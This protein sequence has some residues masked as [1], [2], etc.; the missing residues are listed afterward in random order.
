MADQDAGQTNATDNG[1]NAGGS[2][3]DGAKTDTPKTFTE[4][5][6][7][8]EADRRVS[9]A[10]KKWREEQAELLAAKDKDAETKIKELSSKAEEAQ[11]YGDFVDAAHSAGIRNIKA[12]YAVA[13]AH[14]HIN[15]RGKFDVDAVRK[16]NPEFFQPAANANAGAGAG[17]ATNTGGMNAYIR[18]A[19]GLG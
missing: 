11:R 17:G 16:D 14:G 18:Q 5:D 12:A 9:L 7:Q 13:V 8:R 1:G 19:A 10:Q 2:A 15:A 4:A 3:G 6:I